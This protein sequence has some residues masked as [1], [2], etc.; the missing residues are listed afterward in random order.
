MHDVQK[1][2]LLVVANVSRTVYFSVA[3]VL[4]EL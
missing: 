3:L 1:K 4:G 2:K